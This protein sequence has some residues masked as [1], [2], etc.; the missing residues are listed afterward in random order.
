MKAIGRFPAQPFEELEAVDA[1]HFHIQQDHVRHGMLE[2]VRIHAVAS[3]IINGFLPV[4][5]NLQA[6]MA[7]SFKDVFHEIDVLRVIFDQQE[8]RFRVHS[9]CYHARMIVS[10]PSM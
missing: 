7:G 3:Q 10:S 5:D 9:F 4:L 2:P 1:W 8:S 6:T